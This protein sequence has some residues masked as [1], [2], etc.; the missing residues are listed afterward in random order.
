MQSRNYGTYNGIDISSWEGNVNFSGVRSDGIDIVYIKATEGTG[1]I[2]PYMNSTYNNARN[3]DLKIGFY[4][5]FRA[6]VDAREQARY[7]VENIGD[8]TS[9]CRLALDIETTEGY[10]AVTLTDMCVDFLEEVKS[11][12]GKEVVVYTYSNF[13]QTS[14]TSRLSSYPLWIAAYGVDTP[15]SNSI[16]DRWIGFQYSDTGRVSGVNGNCDLDVFTEE[17]FLSLDVSSTGD[18][19]SSGEEIIYTVKSGDTLSGIA[20]LYGTTWQNLAEINHLSDPNL[21]YPGEKIVINHKSYEDIYIVKPGDTLSGIAQLYGTTWQHLAEINHL[22]NP[23]LIYPGQ[24]IDV[25]F[26]NNN[27]ETYVVKSGDT[28]SGIAQLYGTTW[29]HLAEINN[30]RDPNL[31]YP[32][33][34]INIR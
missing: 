27:S 22:S 29:Q 8:K 33:E 34:V 16:W 25:G 19:N 3:N 9:D 26:E 1:Y 24:S 4:H 2:N 18:Q 21:I 20:H 23:N 10:D 28:L 31:I 12:S 5:F 15:S 6:N 13:A 30:L 17:I 32:G 7:F 11:L 14:L